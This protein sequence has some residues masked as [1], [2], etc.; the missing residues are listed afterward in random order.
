LK[1]CC[2]PLFLLIKRLILSQFKTIINFKFEIAKLKKEN[3]GVQSIQP[4]G[5]NAIFIL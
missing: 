4:I 5:N 2:L 3:F 1:E